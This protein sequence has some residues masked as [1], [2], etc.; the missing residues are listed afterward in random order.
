MLRVIIE[1]EAEANCKLSLAF[2]DG[3]G[4]VVDFT[5]AAKRGGAFARLGDAQFFARV[6][7]GEGGR[8][9][10]WPG[11]LTFR[12]DA[13]WLLCES[14]RTAGVMKQSEKVPGSVDPLL[15]GPA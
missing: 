4:G 7:I 3:T 11:G 14:G 10:K 1:V 9:I 5:P 8:S 13:L 15:H 6:H 2:S 12:A